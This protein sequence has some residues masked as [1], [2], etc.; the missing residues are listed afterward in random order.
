ML[1]QERQKNQFNSLNP[2]SLMK[3]LKNVG[4]KRR[5][6]HKP[7]VF[8]FFFFF[9]LSKPYKHQGTGKMETLE[10]NWEEEKKPEKFGRKLNR[11]LK[12]LGGNKRKPGNSAGKLG[13][14][15]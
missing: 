5:T 4:R 8:D 12:T 15:E 3:T 9:H 11:K 7:P 6:N 1:S 14:E 10:E 13:G 2:K